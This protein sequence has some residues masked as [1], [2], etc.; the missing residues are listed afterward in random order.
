MLFFLWGVFR[1]RR[2]NCSDSL[3]KLVIPSSVVPLDM[4]SP[5]KPFTSLNGDFDKKASQSNSEKQDGRL[6]SN[7]LSENTASNAFL[8]SENRCASPLKVIFFFCSSIRT[9]KLYCMMLCLS[10]YLVGWL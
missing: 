6:D 1:G 5:C 3:N 2:S 7:S 10:V 9:K 8:C 4:N